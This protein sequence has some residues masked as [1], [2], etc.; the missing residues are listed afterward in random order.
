MGP[1]ANGVKCGVVE[2]V[3]RNVMRW[4]GHIEKKN[5]EKFVKKVHVSEIV[6]PS[7]RGRP[8]VRW[9]D[10]VKEYLHERVADRGGGIELARRQCLNRE[11]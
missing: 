3:K 6:V 8:V 10:K 2:W 11:R 7:R 1:C 9:K 4:V 5:N